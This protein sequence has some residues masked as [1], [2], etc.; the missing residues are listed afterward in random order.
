MDFLSVALQCSFLPIVVGPIPDVD[1]DGPGFV[2]KRG[3]GEAC[4]A[5]DRVHIDYWIRDD[6][7]K[8]IANSERRGLAY[9]FDLLG[10][11]GDL[12]LNGAALGAQPGEERVMI[13]FAEDWNEELGPFS[14]I[15]NPGPLMVRIR[16]NRVDRR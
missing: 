2:L 3:T 16:V 6:S 8:E 5:G 14:L 15:R 12:L 9:T 1:L 13:V 4:K 7:G 11:P 10:K